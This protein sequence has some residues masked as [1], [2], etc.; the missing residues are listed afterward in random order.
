MQKLNDLE[1]AIKEQVL[2]L[3]TNF[4]LFDELASFDY[5]LF[6]KGDTVG[7]ALSGGKDSVALFYT[8]L[9]FS[10]N[11]P[12]TLVAVNVDHG[13]RGEQSVKDSQFVKRL[14]QK[15]NV[16]LYFKSVDS[17]AYAKENKTS[18]EN[19]A[20]ILRYEFFEEL[21]DKKVFNKLALGHHQND[22]AETVIF[23]ILRGCGIKGASGIASKRDYFV[24]PML[25]VKRAEIDNLV[26][27]NRLPFVV[28]ASNFELDPTRNYIRQEIIP[29]M[30][31]RFENT[32]DSIARFSDNMKEVA[33]D[34][35]KMGEA[36]VKLDE[37]NNPYILLTD[38]VYPSVF[39][40]SVL[41]ALT[42]LGLNKDVYKANLDDILCLL[43]SQ[44]GA[45]VDLVDNI[46]AIK[47][48]DRITFCKKQASFE[49]TCK[50]SPCEFEFN[51][52]KFAIKFVK[53]RIINKNTL[54]IDFDKLPKDAIIRTRRDGDILLRQSGKVKLKEYLIDKK[55]VKRKRDNMLFIASENLIYAVIP[56]ECGKPLF[57]DENTKNILCIT[58]LK[59]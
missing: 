18:L 9:R 44:S 14:C 31:E 49:F 5:S 26:A 45:R 22:N 30:E 34:L 38:C 43:Q 46:C 40:Q 11:F 54:C 10:K 50:I 12:I 17:K 41:H 28:D 35:R 13:I 37:D 23:N 56:S 57:V 29:K 32:T 21:Y 2:N 4:V 16:P 42:I 1:N 53:E 25:K 33:N 47:D 48:Y 39:K 24:R 55:I 20:R 19:A 52:Q 51:N 6:E 8:L 3:K 59:D 58:L 36:A 27:K 7:V 15:E